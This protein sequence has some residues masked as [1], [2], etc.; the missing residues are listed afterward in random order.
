MGMGMGMINGEWLWGWRV[1]D[2]EQPGTTMLEWCRWRLSFWR[3]SDKRQETD[4]DRTPVPAW[5]LDGAQRKPASIAR[6]RRPVGSGWISL[7]TVAIKYHA[8]QKEISKTKEKKRSASLG[9]ICTKHKPVVVKGDENG[10]EQ[11]KPPFDAD[12]ESNIV[13]PIPRASTCEIGI[14]SRTVHSSSE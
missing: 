14:R 11:T 12:G 4:R 1:D 6:N 13:I 5:H 7:A 10:A 2:Q 3:T 8:Q 9:T